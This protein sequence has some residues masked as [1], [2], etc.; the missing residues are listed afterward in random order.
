MDSGYQ[1][2]SCSRAKYHPATAFVAAAVGIRSKAILDGQPLRI[3]ARNAREFLATTSWIDI[4]AHVGHGQGLCPRCRAMNIKGVRA[5][6]SSVPVIPAKAGIH[7]SRGGRGFTMEVGIHFS[8][9]I[10]KL[11][12][13]AGLQVAD[14]PDERTM[15][16]PYLR[17]T[18]L[19]PQSLEYARSIH[20]VNEIV[21]GT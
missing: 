17:I 8:R 19:G 13:S 14:L 2:K 3:R 4:P 1:G 21:L 18:R 7:P 10:S 20:D 6:E 15:E 5:F 12:S 16:I 11:Q 9:R